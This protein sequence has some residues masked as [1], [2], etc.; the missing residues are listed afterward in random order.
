MVIEADKYICDKPLPDL[1][2]TA[3]DRSTMIAQLVL[4]LRQ[5]VYATKISKTTPSSE[6]NNFLTATIKLS[7]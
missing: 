7:E 1:V 3:A 6:K 2:Q 4:R 5:H